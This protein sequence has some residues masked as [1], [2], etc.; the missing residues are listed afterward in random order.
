[1][2]HVEP[3][4]FGQG[5]ISDRGGRRYTFDRYHLTDRPKT[6]RAVYAM[7]RPEC[8]GI[9]GYV[10][11]TILYVGRALNVAERL[12]GHEKMLPAINLYA[13]EL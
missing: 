4:A 7:V 2:M 11:P 3:Q 1:M 8:M 12:S 5:W 6:G 9:F 13:S 10:A